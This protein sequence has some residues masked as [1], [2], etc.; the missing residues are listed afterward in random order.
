MAAGD[1]KIEYGS[2]TEVVIDVHNLA[3]DANLLAGR[4]GA[5]VDNATNKFLDYLLSG[6]FEVG[7]TPTADRE[8]RIYVAGLLDGTN[9]PDT[10]L[11]TNANVAITDANVRDTALQLAV[12]IPTDATA[13]QVYY[14]G[15]IS[16]AALFG[17]NIP[18][19]WTVWV[20]QSTGNNFTNVD[21]ENE[22]YITPVYATVAAA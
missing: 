22:I 13:D 6:E 17:G 2:A 19:K 20:V 7:G 4:E 21:A 5:A 15:P 18:A 14:F 11:G 16:V 3:S 12:N 8:I 10:L 9:Y 1:V